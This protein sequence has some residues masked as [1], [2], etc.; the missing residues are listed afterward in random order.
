MKVGLITECAYPASLEGPKSPRE[1][2][3]YKLPI[4]D[5]EKKDNLGISEAKFAPSPSCP[6]EATQ[7]APRYMAR[8]HAGLC[9]WKGGISSGGGAQAA[10]LLSQGR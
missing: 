9:S 2:L 1:L 4:G 3:A 5:R 8:H 6:G 7:P 10:G